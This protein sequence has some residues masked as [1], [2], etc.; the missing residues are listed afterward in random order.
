MTHVEV[1]G[2]QI[3]QHPLATHF[4]K[5]AFNSRPRYLKYTATWDVDIV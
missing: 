1:D 3:G 4:L 2:V 5:G